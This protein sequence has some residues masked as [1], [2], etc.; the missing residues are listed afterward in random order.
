MVALNNVRSE[1]EDECFTMME[2]RNAYMVLTAIRLISL[3]D[4]S[5]DMQHDHT[6]IT[7]STVRH[8]AT[9]EQ[10]GRNA[11]RRQR[12]QQVV[13]RTMALLSHREADARHEA[14]DLLRMFVDSTALQQ[15]TLAMDYG[16]HF[17]SHIG[18]LLDLDDNLLVLCSMLKNRIY[19]VRAT[20]VSA[21]G[22]I[23]H[24]FLSC[25]DG[26]LTRL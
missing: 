12:L 21:F 11:P 1:V 22:T 14:L 26:T 19:F 20:A 4:R 23:V 5:R 13:H 7:Y 17:F 16:S 10:E 8:G 25:S 24:H 9:D 6:G 2:N 18:V 3:L 15:L